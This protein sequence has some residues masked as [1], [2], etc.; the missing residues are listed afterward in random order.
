[1]ILV[2]F[3]YGDR[4]PSFP[5]VLGDF[6]NGECI[7]FVLGDFGLYDYVSFLLSDSGDFGHGDRIPSIL[8]DFFHGECIN[9]FDD[10]NHC[11]CIPSFYSVW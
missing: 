7:S 3:G 5:L 10:F 2:D 8:C 6:D 1:M 11:N 4:V 9:L